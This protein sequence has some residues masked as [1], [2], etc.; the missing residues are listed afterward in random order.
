MRIAQIAPLYESV[1]PRYYGGTER[2]VAHLSNALVQRGHEV[3]LFASGDSRTDAHLVPCRDV[4]VRLDQDICWDLPAHLAMLAKVREVADAFDIVHFHLDCHHFPFFDDRA[5]RTLTTLHGRQDLKDLQRLYLYYPYFP[6]V[7]ISDSQRRPVPNLRWISTVHHGLPRDQYEF[8]PK[9][10]GNYLAFLG[11]IA[12]EKGVDRSIAIAERAGMPLRIAAKIDF[13]DRGYFKE[14]IAP[15]LKIA[16]SA[17]Y[18]GEIAE[19]EKETFLGG[20]SA[21]LFPIDWPEPFGLV[22][23]EAM[24][25]GTPVIAFNRGSVSEIVEHGVTGFIVETMEEAV[26]A[27]QRAPTLDRARIRESFERR[28]TSETMAIGYEAAY[29]SVLEM[30]GGIVVAPQSAAIEAELSAP[31]EVSEPRRLATDAAA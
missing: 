23:I 26:A 17:E 24:A 3:V 31:V 10:T 1:P 27:A 13:A 2:V 29:R 15:L 6:L 22:M 20:A 9:A 7:S 12:P 14:H 8:S 30:A 25:C 18:I 5:E 4:A 19:R 21:L 16:A 11:R 28:F